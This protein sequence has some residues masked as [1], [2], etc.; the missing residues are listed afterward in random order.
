MH[1][2][3]TTPQLTPEQVNGL[4]AP[5]TGTQTNP[6]TGMLLAVGDQAQ[7]THGRND[8][9]T[10]ELD[11]LGFGLDAEDIDPLGDTSLVYR[12]VNGLL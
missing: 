3:S 12:D 10:T 1:A 11:W 6:A 2:E 4:A 8:V 7:Y 5:G 9:W